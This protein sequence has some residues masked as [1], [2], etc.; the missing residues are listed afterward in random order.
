[1]QSEVSEEWTSGSEISW[2]SYFIV[3]ISTG[4][5]KCTPTR[6]ASSDSGGL[7][8]CGNLLTADAYGFLG[9]LDPQCSAAIPPLDPT[10]PAPNPFFTCEIFSHGKG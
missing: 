8:W 9:V 3:S 1:M 10:N 2:S 4:L 6:E 5:N 7:H